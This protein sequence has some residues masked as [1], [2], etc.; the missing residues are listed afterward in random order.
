MSAVKVL[1]VQSED[2]Q[3][4][5]LARALHSY[6][7]LFRAADC[8]QARQVLAANSDI[9]VIVCDLTLGDGNWWCVHQELVHQSIGAELIVLL[10]HA[11]LGAA[12]VEAHGATPIAVET[13]DFGP[14]VRA[15]DHAAQ[16]I[17]RAKDSAEAASAA[18]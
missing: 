17:A 1:L 14:V 13:A 7:N 16:V 12:G 6:P 4:Q 9:R 11:G 10:P 5:R 2:A 3:R 8:E 15:V 18:R